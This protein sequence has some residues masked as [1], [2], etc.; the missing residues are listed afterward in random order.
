[1]PPMWTIVVVPTANDVVDES[2]DWAY[3]APVSFLEQ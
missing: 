1:M 2:L 3:G